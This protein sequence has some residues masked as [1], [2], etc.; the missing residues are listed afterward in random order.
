MK[1][2]LED[3][4]VEEGK[5]KKRK[6]GMIIRSRTETRRGGRE[7]LSDSDDKNKV[8]TEGKEEKLR[9]NHRANLKM[10]CQT[11]ENEKKKEG[12]NET[13]LTVARN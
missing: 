12:R 10:T 7:V 2:G 1:Q 9:M 6:G 13:T 11:Q 4:K 8:K 3:E 5:R